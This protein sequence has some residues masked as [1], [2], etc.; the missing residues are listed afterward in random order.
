MARG[1]VLAGTPSTVRGLPARSSM[2]VPVRWRRQASNSAR[3]LRA[4]LLVRGWPGL[5]LSVII[6]P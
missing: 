2:P 1:L 3:A 6:P 4:A 5:R